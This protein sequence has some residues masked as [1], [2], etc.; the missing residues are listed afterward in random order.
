MGPTVTS[1]PVPRLRHVVPTVGPSAPAPLREA[2]AEVLDSIE[3]AVAVS[4]G[5]VD[6]EVVLAR[7]PDEPGPDR[8]TF[9]DAPVLASSSLDV[10]GPTAP[11][12]LPLLRQVLD[13][14]RAPGSYDALILTNADIGL[15]PEFYDIVVDIL[16]DGHDAFCINRR[17]VTARHGGMGSALARAQVGAPHPGHDCFV[18]V[19]ELLEGLDVGDVLLGTRY[20]ASTLLEAL[21]DRALRF[22]VF[23]DLHATFHVGDD[24]P[25]Q[26]PEHEVLTESNLRASEAA[27]QRRAARRPEGVTSVRALLGSLH[28]GFRPRRLVFCAAPARSGTAFLAN[29]LAV[30][31]TVDAG[32][33]RGPT[34]SGPWLRDIG[35]QGLAATR[36]HRRVKADAIAVELDRLQR[37]RVY[38]DTSH[39]FL[40]AFHDVVLDGFDH[41]GLQVIALRRDPVDVARSMHLLGWFSDLN[42]TWPDWFLDPTR[43][44]SGLDIGSEELDGPLDRILAHLAEVLA[45]RERLRGATPTVRWIDADLPGLTTRTGANALLAELGLRAR[46]GRWGPQRRRV[47]ARTERK[48]RDARAITRGR[49]AEELD[50]FLERFDDRPALAALREERA[51]WR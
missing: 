50:A 9:L 37:H 21:R 18:L 5:R 39:L 46:V 43:A 20:V 32:H 41:V 49:I 15:Q 30:A 27:R 1:S 42:P 47:N 29:L 25:W 22:R 17:S 16:A 35:E 23:G 3:R 48:V 26:R 6:V 51:R 34:M 19:P 31:P 28:P 12:R 44:A 24:R 13:A 45:T 11:R 10:V 2:H 8:P 40:T 14:F 7:F 4:A 36:A 33:E 38:V